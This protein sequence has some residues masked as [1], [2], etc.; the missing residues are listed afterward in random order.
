MKIHLTILIILL[1][2]FNSC[3]TEP[4]SSFSFRDVDTIEVLKMGTF[5]ECLVKSTSEYATSVLWDFG[6]GR[7][8]TDEEIILSYPKSGTYTLKLFARNDAGETVSS[9]QVIVLDRVLKSIVI[10]AVQ[11]NTENTEGW[12]T[13]SLVDIYFQIQMFTDGTMNPTGIYPNCPVLFTSSTVENINNQHVPPA[14]NPIVIPATEKIIIDKTLVQWANA[15][16]HINKA[17]LFSLMAKD[18]DG[19]IFCL[20][21]NTQFGGNSFGIMQDDVDLNIFK[22]RF[23]FFSSV[24]LICE[25]E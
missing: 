18:S 5:D 7:S 4:V 6:D 12:P 14:F 24:N 20:E 11:W 15:Y 2:L 3:G 21:N 13:T 25:F 1:V 23:S 17:Y 22:I 8:S 10:D 16:D 9:K 19:N